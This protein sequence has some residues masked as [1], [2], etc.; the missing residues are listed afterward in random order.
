MY[1]DGVKQSRILYNNLG[2]ILNLI[3]TCLSLYVSSISQWLIFRDIFSKIKK[4]YIRSHLTRP[5]VQPAPDVHH[6]A[7]TLS[8]GG[9]CPSAGQNGA[10]GP[11]GAPKALTTTHRLLCPLFSSPTA[12]RLGI[13]LQLPRL[14]SDLAKTS[15]IKN[16]SPKN[17]T[18]TAMATRW[19][20]RSKRSPFTPAPDLTSHQPQPPHPQL[21]ER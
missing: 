9:I 3:R 7:T 19:L 15:E 4:G 8:P 21:S 2:Q 18:L 16:F 11:R 6:L 14:C 10:S 13:L 5:Y 12:T 17:T 20:I 1:I